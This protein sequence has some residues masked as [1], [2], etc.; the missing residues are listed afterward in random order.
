MTKEAASKRC[1]TEG[2]ALR[3]E[4]SRTRKRRQPLGGEIHRET[5]SP[6]GPQKEPALP[7]P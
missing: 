4:G 7:T 6:P 3:Q 5:D 1:Y 2:G